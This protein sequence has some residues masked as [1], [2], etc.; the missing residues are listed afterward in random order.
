MRSHFQ[1]EV[2]LTTSG[3][4]ANDQRK[5]M[6]MGKLEELESVSAEF[7]TALYAPLVGEIASIGDWTG[8]IVV[9]M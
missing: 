6:R 9:N 4:A 2:P 8:L 5:R 7:A 3:K 1:D